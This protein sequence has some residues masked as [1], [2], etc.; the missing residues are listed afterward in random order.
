M[1][2]RNISQFSPFVTFCQHIIPLAYDESMSYYE[3][4]CALRDYLVNTVIP[5]VNNNADA[6]TELQESYT[7]F[8]KTIN[9]KVSEL[10]SYMDN[11]FKNLDVQTEINNK[12]DEMAKSGEL[13]EI[14]GQYLELNSVLAFN[15]RSDLK[16]ANNLNN[17]SFTY[18]FGKNTYNDGYG[19]F[20]K[21]R[22]SINT[23]VADD[24]NIIALTNYP[25][26]IAEKMPNK[27]LSDSITALTDNLNALTQTVTD[28]YNTLNNKIENYEKQKITIVL[29]DSWTGEDSNAARGG[30]VTWVKEFK[31]FTKNLVINKAVGGAGFFRPGYTTFAQQFQQVLDDETIDKSLID[32]IIIYG[33]LNDIDNCA[34]NDIISGGNALGTLI[35]NNCE[36]AK[37]YCAFFNLARRANTQ[38]AISY[39]SQFINA[40]A[41]YGWNFNRSAGWIKGNNGSLYA[42]DGYHPNEEGCHRIVQCMLAFINGTE[43]LSIPVNVSNFKLILPDEIPFNGTFRN[44]LIYYPLTGTVQGEVD[45]MFESQE[46]TTD[47]NVNRYLQWVL[48]TDIDAI[49]DGFNTC[50]VAYGQVDTSH[51]ECFAQANCSSYSNSISMYIITDTTVL[52]NNMVKWSVFAYH[53]N[54]SIV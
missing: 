36:Y 30:A 44:N 20:Y 17:G 3:T 27:Y 31:T 7:N 39:T 38:K 52:L 2:N 23:D 14:I 15:T 6:V 33:G 46:V 41:K 21:I 37:V 40:M 26:L 8:I 42:S 16:N 19:N 49:T 10:E 34:I 43:G 5:A 1:N 48:Q 50:N 28:N 4:L 53:V 25:N 51:K 24:D 47:P 22:E 11:Y 13:T 18:C 32:T 54:Y 35:Q 45:F 29:G 12:L 9:N